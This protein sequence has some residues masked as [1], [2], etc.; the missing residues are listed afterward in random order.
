[1][2]RLGVRLETLDAL[3]REL[4]S[5]TPGVELT[6]LCTHLACA[7]ERRRRQASRRAARAFSRQRAPRWRAARLHGRALVHVANS[8]APV[9][10]ADARCEPGAARAGAL[11]P[12]AVGGGGDPG[13]R[14]GDDARSRAS[15]RCASSPAGE[16]RLVRRAVQRG[17]AVA[18]R[19]RARRLRRRLHAPHD[20]QGRGARRRPRC[21]VVGA[22]TM[23]MC[24]V[25]VTDCPRPGS[26]TRSCCSARRAK[27][28]HRR[29]RARRAGR[30]RSRGRSSAASASAC[31]A[32]TSGS[33]R[34]RGHGSTP[35]ARIDEPAPR[36]PT[37]RSRARRAGT[38]S[39][40]STTSCGRRRPSS[41]RSSATHMMLLGAGGVLAVHAA[42]P[43][44]RAPRGDGV[45]RRAVAR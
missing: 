2:S 25:D 21:P 43:R 3:L 15:W 41:S 28:A 13:L 40:R 4:S 22:I 17:A 8:A 45:H 42:V 37:R 23:D 16:P 38:R 14:A 1:M 34:E 27:R 10:F 6:G 36:Q 44:R 19:H 33:G 7:D 29:R 12:V 9:R 30:A 18:H 26:A 11:R 31:R 39:S 20:R 24:M 5:A 32:S 35:R